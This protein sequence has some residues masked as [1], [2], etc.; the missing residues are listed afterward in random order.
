[1]RTLRRTIVS[2][3]LV[4]VTSVSAWGYDFKVD[5]I[6]YSFVEDGSG[7]Y[8]S[9]VKNGDYDTSDNPIIVIPSAITYDGIEYPVISIGSEAFKDCNNYLQRI[10]IP[11][12][13]E[14]IGSAAFKGCSLIADITIPNCV[15]GIGREAFADCSSLS[16]I[17]IPENVTNIRERVFSGCSSL[18]TISLPA[19]LTSIEGS[20]FSGCSSLTSIDIPDGVTSIG[21]QAFNGCG[22]LTSMN[23]PAGVTSIGNAAFGFDSQLLHLTIKGNAIADFS[24]ITGGTG[25]LGNPPLFFVDEGLYDQYASTPGWCDYNKRI[26]SAEMLKPVTVEV[27]ATEDESALFTKLGNNSKYVANLKIIG[28]INGYDIMTL[29]NKTIHLLYLDLSEANI[30]A[31]DGGY[32]YYTGCSL[33]ADNVLGFHS[34]ADLLLEEIILPKSLLSIGDN[35]FSGCKLLEKVIFQD[36]LLSIGY[37]AFKG[38]LLKEI[39]L[40][41]SL[42]EIGGAAFNN[43]LKL[44]GLLRIPDKITVIKAGTF[45]YTGIDSLL[46]GQNVN[47]IEDGFWDNGA[48]QWCLNLN[49]IKFNRKL[50]NIGRRAFYYCPRLTSADLPYTVETIEDEAFKSCALESI[51][52]PSMT[53]KIGG[54]A[55]N[56]CDNIK[57]IYTYTVEP[58]SINQNTFSSICFTNAMLNVPKTSANLYI[59][60]TQWSQFTDVQEF[61]EPYDAF[62]LNGDVE[63]DDKTGRMSGE[64]DAEMNEMSGFIIEGDDVQELSTIELQHNGKDGASL[65]GSS[66]SVAGSASNLTAKSMKVN[67]TVEGNRWYFFCFPFNVTRDSIECTSEYAIY[68]YDGLKRAGTGSGWAKLDNS[69]TSL[70]KGLGYIFQAS[71]TGV[72][73][74]HVGSEY[75]SFAANNESE[76]L[77]AYESDDVT[78]ASW[79][80]IGNPFISYYDVQDLAAEYD[81]PI[82]VWNGRGYDVYKPGDDD[83]QLKPFEA[84]FVQ[85][86]TG[87]GQVNFLP[88]NRITYNQGLERKAL[89][90]KQRA[91]MG[92]PISVD[93]QL[94]NITIMDKD[95]V[96]DRTRIVYNTKASMDYEIGVDASKFHADGVPQIYTLNGTAKYAINERPMGGDDIK[97]GYIAPKAGVYTLSVPRQDAEIEIYDNVAQAVVDF[98]FGDYMFESKAGTFNDRFVVRKTGGVT[99]VEGGFRLDGLTVT[100]TNGGLDIEGKMIGKVS[101]YNEAGM[102]LAEPAQTGRI[103][104]S[105]GVYIV[106]IGE[107]SIKMSVL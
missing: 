1:M 102:L 22:S 100:A 61:D 40:P 91:V 99:S 42:L 106:K 48:F 28:S 101:V 37:E 12:S 105:D 80:F 8:V 39:D 89:L 11:E 35:A 50:K 87:K 64:P 27:A 57:N 14:I 56:E 18:T 69:F 73:T 9:V 45:A 83:Y 96:T 13:L 51:K 2:L 19:G 63:L 75:L 72:L 107:R 66:G 24:T 52:I 7:K 3:A 38:C 23:I 6:A 77:H 32:E 68:S 16:S 21:G 29:R 47:S 36:G 59:Y 84:F 26:I 79:N 104:L 20:A 97:L 49:Y 74:I 62:Y 30:V 94:V 33:N 31:N 70:Q 60:N 85:K 41:S 103:E 90:A 82:I 93:R 44:S 25:I 92:T 15:R 88:D 98:T 78:N 95:S 54:N 65:I 71:K 67:I 43:C 55:F 5:G 58:T 46:I 10:I 86:Q 34:F 76:L 4:L 53:K 81:A 17:I